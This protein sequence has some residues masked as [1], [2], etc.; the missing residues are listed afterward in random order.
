MPAHILLSGE[1]VINETDRKNKQT[2][3]NKKINLDLIEV[4]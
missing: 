3:K 2:K 4:C 1:V